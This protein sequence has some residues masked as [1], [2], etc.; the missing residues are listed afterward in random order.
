MP[1]VSPRV[2]S[3]ALFGHSYGGPVITGAGAEDRVPGRV[4]QVVYLDAEV[5]RDGEA[6]MDLLP[7]DERSAYEVSAKLHREGW[8]IAPPVPDSLPL[9]L[10][11]EVR[12]AMSRMV[13]QPLRTFTQLL[14][15]TS[16]EPQFQRTY[17]LHTEGKEHNDLPDHVQRIRADSDWRLVELAP[18]TARTSPLHVSWLSKLK[19]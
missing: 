19:P 5:P 13:P 11:P 6:Q 10:D 14:R 9:G 16:A 4:A 8:R 3:H 18:A 12:W 7:P 1:R 17:V 15:L 2:T